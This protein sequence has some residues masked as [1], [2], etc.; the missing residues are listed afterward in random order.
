MMNEMQ[1]RPCIHHLS[2]RIHPFAAS[3]YTENELFDSPL[4]LCYHPSHL[5]DVQSII[6]D[7]SRLEIT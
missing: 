5:P 4:L 1:G 2:F 3:F 6:R 7:Q